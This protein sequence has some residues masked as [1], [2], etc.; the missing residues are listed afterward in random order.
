MAVAVPPFGA[1]YGRG[2]KVGELGLG[3]TGARPWKVIHLMTS[4]IAHR[5]F[6]PVCG[7]RQAEESWMVTDTGNVLRGS[8]VSLFV[9]PLITTRQ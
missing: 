2:A 7:C 1:A 5:P 4:A 8:T 3:H 9:C 6:D